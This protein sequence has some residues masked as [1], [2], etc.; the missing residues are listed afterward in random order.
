[1][2]TIPNLTK[3][4]KAIARRLGVSAAD[5]YFSGHTCYGSAYGLYNDYYSI[6]IISNGYNKREIYRLLLRR[7]FDRIGIL[8][9][10]SE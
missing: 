9:S 4:E 8:E 2:F 6:S 1:M 5:V 7:L 3:A 10:V